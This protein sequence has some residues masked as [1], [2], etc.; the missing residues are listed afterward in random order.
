MQA[1]SL[2]VL[3][4]RVSEKKSRCFPMPWARGFSHAHE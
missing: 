1:G 2:A 4:T 3:C